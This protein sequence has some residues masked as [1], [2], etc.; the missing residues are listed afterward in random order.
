M[1]HIGQTYSY[2]NQNNSLQTF[3]GLFIDRAVVD[4]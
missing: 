1:E 3:K 4:L 2:T